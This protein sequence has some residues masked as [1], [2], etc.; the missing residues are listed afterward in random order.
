MKLSDVLMIVAVIAGPILAVQA[1]KAIERWAERRN[2]KMEI[3]RTLMA[4]RAAR[5][6]P[7]HVRALN[8]IDLSYYGRR[9]LGRNY[10]TKVEVVV[11]NAWKEYLDQ[12]SDHA[13]ESW[14]RREELFVNLLDALAKSLKIE[15]DRVYLKRN[16]YS[17]VG[18]QKLEDEQVQLRQALL[19]IFEGKRALKVEPFV[20]NQVS[21]PIQ[22]QLSEQK[23]SS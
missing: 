13:V 5:L 19:D 1:Q 12:L 18:H 17:P 20:P 7:E 21:A 11:T 22:K 6:S 9:I 4:T 14:P 15:F 16:I 3:F 2:R 23:P 8:M 10:Q